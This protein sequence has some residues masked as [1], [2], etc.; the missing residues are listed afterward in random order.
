M[1]CFSAKLHQITSLSSNNRQARIQL[2]LVLSANREN[3]ID[4]EGKMAVKPITGV[5]ISNSI[6]SAVY[7]LKDVETNVA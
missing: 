3:R 6:E 4:P 1:D 7:L 2:L 5:C